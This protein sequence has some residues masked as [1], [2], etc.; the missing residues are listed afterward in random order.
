MSRRGSF[1]LNEEQNFVA[2]A[3]KYAVMLLFS[4]SSLKAIWKIFIDESNEITD[5][6][7]GP[8]DFYEA[9]LFLVKQLTFSDIK[10]KVRF[11]F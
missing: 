4:S 6:Q 2:S 8:D 3:V 10:E 7:I 11:F 9:F 1:V 5:T